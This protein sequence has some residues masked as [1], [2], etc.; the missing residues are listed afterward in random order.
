M[1]A[2]GSCGIGLMVGGFERVSSDSGL[3]RGQRDI[4]M[5]CCKCVEFRQN[6]HCHSRIG[7][8]LSKGCNDA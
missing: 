4:K 7:T 1:V 8:T 3:C 5:S 6:G 2:G